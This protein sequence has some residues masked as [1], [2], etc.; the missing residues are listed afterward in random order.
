LTSPRLVQYASCVVRELTSLRDVQSASRPVRE[1]AIR[2]LSSNRPTDGVHCESSPSDQ[3]GYED[4]GVYEEL[5]LTVLTGR[6][7]SLPFL[8]KCLMTVCRQAVMGRKISLASHVW[9]IFAK[10]HLSVPAMSV[11]IA[12]YDTSV[13]PWIRLGLRASGNLPVSYVLTGNLPPM[14]Y[15]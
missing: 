4:Q 14:N 5:R 1:L 11:V 15:R 3:Q 6:V 7:T 13:K 10:Q 2:E 9:Q 8:P 12:G